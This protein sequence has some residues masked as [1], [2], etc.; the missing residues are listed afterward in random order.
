MEEKEDRTTKS[1]VVK[2][3]RYRVKISMVKPYEILDFWVKKPDV[4]YAFEFFV[5]KMFSL[6]PKEYFK[7][8][9]SEV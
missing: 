1:R 7:I 5:N 8:E 6:N 9:V 4:I 3:K 2:L